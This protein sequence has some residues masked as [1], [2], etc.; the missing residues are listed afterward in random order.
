YCLTMMDRF[1]RWPEAIPLK[2]MTAGSVADAF[3][4]HWICRFG[5]PLYI[6]TDQGSQFETQLF[7]TLTRLV[8]TSRI[9]T[10][11]YHL[12]SNGMIERWHRT[13]KAALI[14]NQQVKWAE[15]L[16]MGYARRSTILLGKIQRAHKRS[17]TNSYGPPQQ[18]SDISTEWMDD[19]RFVIDINGE[20]CSVAIER[21]KPT[22]LHD[23]GHR[24]FCLDGK[25]GKSKLEP[26]NREGI[27][28]DFA[29]ESKGYR[30]WLPKERTVTESHDAKFVGTPCQGI[31]EFQDFS[32]QD[33]KPILVVGENVRDYVEIT[34]NPHIDQLA[35]GNALEGNVEDQLTVND[36]APVAEQLTSTRGPG[37]PRI[38]KT[39]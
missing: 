9:R 10:T 19:R 32:P 6:T 28:V 21:L 29:D 24:V 22:H 2:D 12:S 34:L 31:G 23:F 37:R 8:G 18:G 14:C 35:R 11:P 1:L 13:L 15:L 5:T 33:C 3:Y 39:G 7:K 20:L 36:D 4:Q 30:V 38:V 27:L 17:K 26:R 16:L 25:P